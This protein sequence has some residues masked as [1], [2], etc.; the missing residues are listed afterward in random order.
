MHALVRKRHEFA[1]DLEHAVDRGEIR[2]V[3]QPIVSLRTGEIVLFEALARWHHPQHGII[4]PVE[5]VPVAEATG[6]MRQIGRHIMLEACRAARTWQDARPDYAAAGVSVNLS[7]A[8]FA[9]DELVG[10]VA[11]ALAGSGLAPQSL[12]LELTES[13][14]M[15]DVEQ[16]CTRMR[17]LRALGVRLALDDFGTGH[18]SL[19]RLDAL[20][21]N[22]LKIAKPFVD[23]LMGA[24]ADAS[25]VEAFVRLASSLKLEVV[26]EG[27]ETEIQATRLREYGYDL[28]QGYH[29]AVPLPLDELIGAQRPVRAAA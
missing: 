29:F 13:A 15:D 10:D 23:K 2:V 19:E 8:E 25:F 28:G 18:S 11:A 7:P 4:S 9:T 6:T 12:T 20:P 3:F 21:L 17:E 14:A 24:T 5:F 16:V 1:L 22:V 26:A 27:V